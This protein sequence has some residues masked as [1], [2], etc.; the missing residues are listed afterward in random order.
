MSRLLRFVFGTT[1]REILGTVLNYALIAAVVVLAVQLNWA[2]KS[3][4]PREWNVYSQAANDR[5]YTNQPEVAPRPMPIVAHAGGRVPDAPEAGAMQRL[6][7]NYA[8]GI[9][10]FELDF[11][12]TADNR[13]VVEHDWNKRSQIPTLQQYLDES[14]EQASLPMVFSWMEDH[15]EAFVVTD[16][17][18]RSLEFVAR[19]RMERPD[20]VP[21]FLVQIYQFKDLELVRSQG[22]RHVIL[23][24]YRCH[25]GTSDDAIVEFAQANRLWAVTMPHGRCATGDL[26]SRLRQQGI[27]VFAH[28]V[29]D[30]ALA[31]RL[32]T[33]GCQGVYSD[34][35]GATSLPQSPLIS[36]RPGG[37]VR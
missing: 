25:M 12:W 20:L 4:T 17:K 30:S 24:L 16:C 27:A 21:R 33:L 31:A 6:S 15:P 28:T 29:N 35:L 10:L 3:P 23:T 22:F 18:K 2:M 8:L 19:V 13:L 14:P 26:P 34:S 1:R 36:Q 7:H 5:L 37:S 9:R 11:S 32:L